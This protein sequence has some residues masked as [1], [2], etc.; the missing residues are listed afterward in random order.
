[1]N[2]NERTIIDRMAE[3][4][5]HGESIRGRF[6][7]LHTDTQQELLARVP[8]LLQPLTRDERLNAAIEL[9]MIAEMEPA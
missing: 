3:C 5:E 8:N 4:L 9:Q 2:A 7:I 6:A 1:M